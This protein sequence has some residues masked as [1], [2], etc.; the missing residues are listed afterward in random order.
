MMTSTTRLLV[1]LATAAA[2]T[3]LSTMPARADDTELF[4]GPAVTAPPARPNILFIVDT[5]G[6]MDEEQWTQGEF[7]PGET[8]SGSCDRGRLYWSRTGTPPDCGSSMDYI[9]TSAFVCNNAQRSLSLNGYAVVERAAQWQPR[10][11]STVPRTLLAGTCAKRLEQLRRVRSGCW[12]SRRDASSS[13]RYAVNGSS[14]AWQSSATLWPGGETGTVHFYSGNYL[15][16][17]ADPDQRIRAT[18]LTSSAAL[19]AR[20]SMASKTTS[21]SA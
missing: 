11:S 13:R 10:V 12:Y 1:N 4:V 14:D 2:V 8:Y 16:Y 20:C 17:R 3:V 21:T 18:R 19:C 6:S 5:S 9:S 7:I 15:N